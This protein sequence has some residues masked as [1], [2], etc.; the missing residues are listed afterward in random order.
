MKDG[1][2]NQ[3][4]EFVKV[5]LLGLVGALGA[6]T[7]T[8]GVNAAYFLLALSAT[9][10]AI[11]NLNNLQEWFNAHQMLWIGAAAGFFFGGASFGPIGMGFGA[12]LGHL[13]EE[14]V[15]NTVKVVNQVTAPV[16]Y[17]KQTT[18]TIWSSLQGGFNQAYQ[19]VA[20]KEEPPSTK[21]PVKATPII[22]ERRFPAAPLKEPTEV[23]PEKLP[24]K[25]PVSILKKQTKSNSE[26]NNI[27]AKG[28]HFLQT[29]TGLF[30]HQSSNTQQEPLVKKAPKTVTWQIETKKKTATPQEKKSKRFTPVLSIM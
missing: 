29:L 23:A 25:K 26:S 9:G 19:F 11:Y 24:Q 20:G 27:T 2:A 28:W 6:I 18:Q 17:A 1:P 21:A 15:N 22:S 10:A 5:L 7:L 3:D 8:A 16:T 12:W 4:P 30:S 14:Q 13:V